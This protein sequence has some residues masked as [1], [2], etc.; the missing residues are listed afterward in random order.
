MPQIFKESP[1]LLTLFQQHDVNLRHIESRSS[2]RSEGD[3]Y[4]FIIECDSE[5]CGNFP[6]AL[7]EIKSKSTYFNVVS[8]EYKDNEGMDK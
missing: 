3:K 1:F 2:K 7:E 8:R 5:K 6:R 4:E